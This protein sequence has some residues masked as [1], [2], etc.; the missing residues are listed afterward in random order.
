MAWEKMKA[1]AEWGWGK[2]SSEWMRISIINNENKVKKNTIRYF[3]TPLIKAIIN[4]LTN[5]CWPECGKKRNPHGRVE[6]N[7]ALYNHY[8]KCAKVSQKWKI[9]LPYDSAIPLMG[10]YSQKPKTLIW[11]N[12][13]TSIFILDMESMQVAF[14]RQVDKNIVVHIYNG[15]LLG[16]KKQWNYY[17]DSPDGPQSI[18]SSEISQTEKEK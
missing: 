8:G 17:L 1:R 4:K 13:Y 12:I 5:N 7:T 2:G 9:E 15:I 14:N 10:I 11:K 6:G 18:L 3:F 16:H